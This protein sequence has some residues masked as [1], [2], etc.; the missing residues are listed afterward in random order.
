MS[1]QTTKTAK[2]EKST[3]AQSTKTHSAQ[4]NAARVIQIEKVTLNCG[5]GTD[6]NRLEKSVKLLT[7]IAEQQ[8]VKTVTQKRIP[9]WQL[10]PGLPIGVKV[11]LR[12]EKAQSVLARIL[13]SKEKLL[14]KNCFDNNGNV[15]FG[16]HEYINIP[17]V[18]YDPQLGIIGLQVC[19]TLKRSGFRLRTRHIKSA[20]IPK[21]HRISQDDAIAFAKAQWNIRLKEEVE[22]AE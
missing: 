17:G 2:S 15:S 12:G 11:T 21:D 22:Q 1:T 10:R 8:P 16:V 9:N 13:E 20:P 4:S 14:S 3:P 19:V 18:E 7:R 5:C 6:H